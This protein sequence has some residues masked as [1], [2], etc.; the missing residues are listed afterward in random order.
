MKGLRIAAAVLLI[1]AGLLIPAGSWSSQLAGHDSARHAQL[2]TGFWI[3]KILLV[4]HG[5]LLLLAP[6]LL[7]VANRRSPGNNAGSF[8]PPLRH[9]A[10]ILLAVLVAALGLRMYGLDQGLWYD[11]IQTLVDYVRLPLGRL[12]TT[13]DSQN[14]HLLYSLLARISISGLGESAIALRLPAALLGIA[15]LVALYYLAIRVTSRREA[16]LA[17]ALLAFSYHHVWF[18]QNARG[19]T[20][21]M[22]WTILGTLFFFRLLEGERTG[23]VLLG[24]GLSMSLAVYTHLT[25]GIVVATH[26]IVWLVRVAG[27]RNMT[28]ADPADWWFPLAGLGLA[29]SVTL[30]LYGPVLPQLKATVLHPPGSGTVTTEWQN[31]LWLLAEAASGLE[32]GL[33]G[34][35]LTVAGGA[36]VCA[37]GFVSYWRRNRLLVLLM[38]LPVVLTAAA[39]VA[40]RHNLWPR[41]FF[42]AAG[43]AA[44][45][46]LRGIFDLASRLAGSRGERLATVVVVLVIALSGWTVRRA[47]VAKQD[48]AGARA[49]VTSHAGPS[50]AIAVT[51]LTTYPLQRYYGERWPAVSSAEEL[52]ALERSHPT[53]WILYTFPVRLQAVSQ[54]LWARITREYQNAASFPGSVAGGAI[55]V[56]RRNSRAVSSPPSTP[57]SAPI[58]Q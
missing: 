55:I 7:Q 44:L 5:L 12:L 52:Q 15:S 8:S 38:T 22:F 42:F 33:P 58:R 20:G 35:W 1:L 40:M 14:Q 53:V 28:N 39:V 29:G 54:D 32:R 11:E 37:L 17:T 46:V 36:I 57:T 9:E 4:I 25:A 30:L 31:P 47:W 3:F 13:Y 51:D 10:T 21:L 48:Y 41:F 18:S 6:R 50:D 27:R 56:M 2:V 23:W 26:V 49:F 24:Y 19:Y 45:L 43:F 16:L 34:G